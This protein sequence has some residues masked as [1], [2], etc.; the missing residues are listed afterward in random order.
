MSN[1]ATCIVC[2]KQLKGQQTKYCSRDCKN[3][4]LQSYAAQKRRGLAR[5]QELVAEFGGQCSRCGYRKNLA[6]LVFHHT[7]PS[8]KDFKL[9]MRSLSNRKF[10][11]VR[12]EIEKCVLFCANCHAEVH[13]PHLEMD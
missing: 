7:G 2:G 11:A 9:D 8:G 5:K 13:N 3:K 4:D 6:A 12:E 10:E 1:L